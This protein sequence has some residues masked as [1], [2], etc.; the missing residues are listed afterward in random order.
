MFVNVDEPNTRI[1]E[2][3]VETNVRL[4]LHTVT[5]YLE[6]DSLKESEGDL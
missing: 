5:L 4:Y 6:C 3:H 1:Q 2:P